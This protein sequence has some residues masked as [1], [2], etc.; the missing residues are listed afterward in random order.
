MYFILNKSNAYDNILF[1]FQIKCKNCKQ[2]YGERTNGDGERE[3]ERIDKCFTSIQCC[4]YLCSSISRFAC[5]TYHSILGYPT[6][7]LSN[8][9]NGKHETRDIG[10]ILKMLCQKSDK[11]CRVCISNYLLQCQEACMYQNNMYRRQQQ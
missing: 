3:G 8:I 7:T 1:N 5:F 2:F 10:K 6:N 11:E 9:V 4:T